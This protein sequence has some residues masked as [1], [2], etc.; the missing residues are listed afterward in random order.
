MDKWVLVGAKDVG[1]IYTYTLDGQFNGNL[2]RSGECVGPKGFKPDKI[3]GV[4]GFVFA[5]DKHDKSVKVLSNG[6]ITD[7]VY[8]DDLGLFDKTPVAIVADDYGIYVGYEGGPVVSLGYDMEIYDQ[9]ER[10]VVALE[11]YDDYVWALTFDSKIL[12]FDTE[13]NLV[14]ETTHFGSAVNALKNPTD[15]AIDGEGNFWFS[16]AGNN[17]VTV[18]FEDGSYGVWGETASSRDTENAKI[19]G[20]PIAGSNGSFVPRTIDVSDDYF[21][22][23]RDS[24]Y[25]VAVEKWVVT[26]VADTQTS[27]VAIS[28]TT[29]KYK[30]LVSDIW[31]LQQDVYPK[32]LV[33]VVTGE[34]DFFPHGEYVM[35]D[36]KIITEEVSKESINSVKDDLTECKSEMCSTDMSFDGGVVTVDLEDAPYPFETRLSVV[37]VKGYMSPLLVES[38]TRHATDRSRVLQ[39]EVDI[40]SHPTVAF[41]IVTGK[42][43]ECLGARVLRD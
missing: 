12:K 39:A 11:L 20:D 30:E 17:R 4:D 34:T 38:I 22:C 7:V 37:E 15:F 40:P 24:G 36:G 18:W 27:Y 28:T 1:Q 21:Y 42:N 35:I 19:G 5:T 25:A 6:E 26:R 8:S 9:V 16:D 14:S 43:G 41:A 10:D 33:F 23:T 2:K 3:A 32:A 13:L 31:Q 29:K